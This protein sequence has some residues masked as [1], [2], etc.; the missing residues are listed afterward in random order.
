[1]QLAGG[2]KAMQSSKSQG[3]VSARRRLIRGAFSAPA[4][5]TLYS[6]SAMA[7][8]SNLNCLKAQIANPVYP[9][10]SD[11]ADTYVR[12]QLHTA[13]DASGVPRWYLSGSAITTIA[14]IINKVTVA[15]TN[16]QPPLTTGQWREVTLQ[17]TGGLVTLGPL[18]E[19]PANISQGS[20]YL[21]LRMNYTK[22][23]KGMVY[24]D[25]VGV[26]DG[27]TLGSAVTGSCWTSCVPLA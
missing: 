27:N 3:I 9:G 4:V 2:L 11:G 18:I 25:I 20:K 16:F 17:S 14:T 7:A 6:G 21:A 12:V 19:Q 23:T 8:S 24:V 22:G 26:V 13:P 5:L 15:V 1:M 10:Y